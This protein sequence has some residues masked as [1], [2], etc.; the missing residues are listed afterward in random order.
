[1]WVDYA[2]S[3]TICGLEANN[4][5]LLEATHTTKENEGNEI[6][7]TGKGNAIRNRIRM[8][9]GRCRRLKV[10]VSDAQATSRMLD[11]ECRRSDVTTNVCTY[12]QYCTVCT[13]SAEELVINRSKT[14]LALAPGDAPE[15]HRCTTAILD[16][17]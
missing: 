7:T 16:G 8:S 17:E 2:V 9:L 6:T 15:L 4:C 1:M 11:C 5:G 10:R 14:C 13:G 12:V 3:V